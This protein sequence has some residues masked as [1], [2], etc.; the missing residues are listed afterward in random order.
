MTVKKSDLFS[1][2]RQPVI[3]T[4]MFLVSYPELILAAGKA[5]IAHAGRRR[6]D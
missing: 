5:D 6:R 1:I 4:P 3:C 2:L